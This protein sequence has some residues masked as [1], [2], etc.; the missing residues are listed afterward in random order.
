[1]AIAALLFAALPALAVE[2]NPIFAV[3]GIKVDTRD[4]D[5]A[6]AKV[7]AIQQA[8]VKAFGKLITRLASSA[9]ARRLEKIGQRKIGRMMASLSI[10]NERIGR[11]R[12]IATLTV[13]F[14]P[15][16]IRSLLNNAGIPFF[17]K[18]APKTVILPVFRGPDGNVLWRDNPWRQAWLDL[19]AENSLAPVIIP[20]GD[21]ADTQAIS[22][23]EALAGDE[24]R[25]ESIKFRYEAEAILVAIATPET[26][27]S[28]HATMNG[29]S[30][31][32]R[33]SFDK[34]YNAGPGEDMADVAAR[35]ARRF[36]EVMTV[37]WKKSQGPSQSGAGGGG[38]RSFTV[39]VPYNS[40]EEW[41]YM[42]SQ[43]LTT[44]GVAGVNVN[45]ISDNGAV[46]RLSYSGS[47]PRFQQ[48]LQSYGL[49]LRKYGN[50][51]VLQRY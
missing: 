26:K 28:I 16:K 46:I 19:K 13:R 48:A 38:I 27:N 24:I 12:Y 37:K 50:T 45:S 18:Q 7:K 36:H 22:A 23:D 44:P 29:Q 31:Y 35:I 17:E 40:I 32:G 33:I 21:L 42:R 30:P 43:L 39:S 11:Q 1:M 4:E 20:I 14:L 41:N 3:S 34:V 2:R 25:L 47:F 9:A 51:W 10:E 15:G 8:Q 5:A 6:K 49:D